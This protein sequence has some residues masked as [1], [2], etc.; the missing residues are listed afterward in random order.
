MKIN[1]VDPQKAKD[2]LINSKPMAV[3][4]LD[5][6]AEDIEVDKNRD[7]ESEFSLDDLDK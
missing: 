5:Q 6:I 3:M 7:G 1:I 4:S 2:L